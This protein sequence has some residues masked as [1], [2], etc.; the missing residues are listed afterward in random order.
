MYIVP[1]PPVSAGVLPPLL[2][3]EAAWREDDGQRG[4]R[5][6]G[7]EQRMRD[8]HP[9]NTRSILRQSFSATAHLAV[10]SGA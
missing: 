5:R 7:H 1:L 3:T 6:T 4:G 8:L 9:G 10:Q 2:W